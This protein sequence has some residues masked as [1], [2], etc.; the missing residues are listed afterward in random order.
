MVRK[1][2]PSI[3]KPDYS[4]IKTQQSSKNTLRTNRETPMTTAK[5]TQEKPLMTQETKVQHG[6]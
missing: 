1:E 5:T 6:R 2:R 3:K 4:G